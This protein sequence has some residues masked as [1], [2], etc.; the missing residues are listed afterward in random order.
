MQKLTLSALAIIASSAAAFP[1]FAQEWWNRWQQV[2]DRHDL[3]GADYIVTKKPIPNATQL[4]AN[5]TYFV[6]RACGAGP[7]PA[8]TSSPDSR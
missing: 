5:P 1:A 3:T 4:F 8:V 7:C 6:Y 2:N